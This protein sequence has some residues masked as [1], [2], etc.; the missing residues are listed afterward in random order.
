MRIGVFGG[1]FDPPHL[2]HLVVA[3]D[4]CAALRLDRVLWIPS[5]VPPHK[6][7]TVQAPARTRL[8]LVEAAIEGDPRF[9]ADDLELRRAGPSYTVDTLRELAERHAGA[10]LVLLIG[11]DNL[12]EIPGWR[13][14][15]EILRLARVAV[16]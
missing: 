8:E 7:H 11:A 9:T 1:T 3:S 5:A 10:E 13:E 14:P 4:A 12:R 6:V 2:G 15:G 16:L